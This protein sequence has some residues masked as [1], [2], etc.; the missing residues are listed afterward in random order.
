MKSCEYGRINRMRIERLEEGQIQI[1][2]TLKDIQNSNKEMFNHF[3]DRY[4][5]MFKETAKRMPT[6]VTV[7][8]TC[9]GALLGGLLIWALTNRI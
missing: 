3:T 4:E 8:G 1:M 2:N 5:Q 6:W 7:I 9:G